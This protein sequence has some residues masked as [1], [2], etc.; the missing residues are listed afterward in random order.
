MFSWFKIRPKEV[1][2][3]VD[4]I[5]EPVQSGSDSGILFYY[6]FESNR[7]NRKIDFDLKF[8]KPG[9]A[10]IEKSARN[11]EIYQEKIYQWEHGQYD[12][13]IPGYSDVLPE[14]A[15]NVLRGKIE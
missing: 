10:D 11:T 14:E 1:W 7:G 5:E 8:F 2:R 12:P 4:T 3:H 9:R 13:D 15:V 6:L